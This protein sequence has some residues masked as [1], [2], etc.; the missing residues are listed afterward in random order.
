MMSGKLYS[1]IA[2]VMQVPVPEIDDASGPGNIEKWDSFQALV[3]LDDLELTFGVKFTV[4]EVLN[5][6]TV[7]DIKKNLQNRGILLDS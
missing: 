5:I 1:I 4:E 2:R 6:R 3:L 7:G